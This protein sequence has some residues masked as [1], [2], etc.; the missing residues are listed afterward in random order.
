ML[1]FREYDDHAAV[2]RCNTKATET[3]TI[4]ETYN[5]KPVTVIESKAFQNCTQIESV[6]IPESVT[7]IQDQAF[8]RCLKLAHIALP[9]NL[10]HIGTNAFGGTRFLASMIAEGGMAVYGTY[11]LN[12]KS[13]SG[14]FTLPETITL[15]ADDA[16]A[17]SISLGDVTILNPALI[18]PE[19]AVYN[20]KNAAGDYVYSGTIRADEGSTAQAY[21]EANG[22]Q[23]APL[24]APV[25]RGDIDD[26][27]E[28][29]STDAQLVLSAFAEM[30]SGNEHGL[31][32]TQ[33]T[34]ADIDEDG[35]LSAMDAQ[36]ILEY[37]LNNTVLNTPT[38]WET[39]LAG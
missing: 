35:E 6:E 17:G 3:V 34:A 10:E 33:F 39:L 38:D 36:Y 22:Y 11:L 20:Q 4:P 8:S 27:G 26:N 28:V 29:N 2:V 25:L 14:D 16:L 37:F 21:A 23:Y 7:D 19:H 31:T 9:A 15:L 12:G 32:E 13:V 24:K 18:I 30:I 1:E 5:G